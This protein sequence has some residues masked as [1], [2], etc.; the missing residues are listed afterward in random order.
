MG[1]TARARPC[2]QGTG[3]GMILTAALEVSNR[4]V[5]GPGLLHHMSLP[6]G[7]G[8]VGEARLEAERP[9][10][11]R[12]AAVAWVWARMAEAMGG[13]KFCYDLRVEFKGLA[14]IWKGRGEGKVLDGSWLSGLSSEVWGDRAVH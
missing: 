12:E 9:Q 7:D 1:R 2:A 11:R 10:F 6:G 8:T 14:N 3:A 4:E 5:T 13:E